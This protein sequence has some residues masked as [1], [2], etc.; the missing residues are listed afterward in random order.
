MTQQYT[1]FADIVRDLSLTT[2][3]PYE[4][5]SELRQR[6]KSVHP[7]TTAGGD[8][9]VST[10]AQE[11]YEKIIAALA[12]INSPEDHDDRQLI[13]LTTAVDGIVKPILSEILTAVRGK[14]ASITPTEL[15]RSQA[16]L[17]HSIKNQL[18]T[19][20]HNNRLHNIPLSSLAGILTFIYLVPS[21]ISNHPILKI[22]LDP[23]Y[24]FIFTFVWGTLLIATAISWVIAW[25]EQECLSNQFQ[26][27]NDKT[28]QAT[29]LGGFAHYSAGTTAIRDPF[30][31]GAVEDY[32]STLA[33]LS[34]PRLINRHSEWR[35]NS[36]RDSIHALAGVGPEIVTHLSELIIAYALGQRV[37]CK[38]E[39][40][41]LCPTFIF[42][43]EFIGCH[44]WIDHDWDAIDCLVLVGHLSL[45][46]PNYSLNLA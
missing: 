2:S 31:Q 14:T 39:K 9:F 22:L 8:I 27:L 18:T 41:N 6:L 28:L 19:R 45:I 7:D 36:Y 33:N 20:I 1:S 44:L 5:K 17:Q 26:R 15:Q 42:T 16:A 11:E 23:S 46:R 24:F 43:E 38:D 3:V 25:K 37:V 10:D 40:I 35:N 29:L 21:T 30:T 34:T 4:A 13:P 32:I 12:F